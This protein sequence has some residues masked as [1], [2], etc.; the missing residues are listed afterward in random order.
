MGNDVASL[1]TS[2]S[3]LPSIMLASSSTANIGWES[4]FG[5]NRCDIH[6]VNSG[7]FHATTSGKLSAVHGDLHA[8]V[9]RVVRGHVTRKEA[10]AHDRSLDVCAF[11]EKAHC[12]W[13]HLSRLI[14]HIDY[15]A[16]RR[17]GI[18]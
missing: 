12:G 15:L 8:D 16:T 1:T 9:T 18:G 17:H 4:D 7:E 13:N 11:V 14:L 10:T 6:C 2:N 3:V 5:V